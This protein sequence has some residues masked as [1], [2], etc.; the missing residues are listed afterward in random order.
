VPDFC[1]LEGKTALVTGGSRGIGAA[2]ALELAHAGAAVVIGYRTGEAE[3]E[4]VVSRTGGR[5]VRA[6]VSDPEEAARLVEEAGELDVLVNNAGL[7]RDGLIA[8]IRARTGA[9]SSTRTSAASSTPAGRP[10]AA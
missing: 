9:S 4:E 3:A 10:R 7:T 5:A 1:S 2:I 8:R 6:D